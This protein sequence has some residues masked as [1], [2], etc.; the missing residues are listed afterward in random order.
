M[1]EFSSN[2]KSKMAC[3]CCGFKFFRHRVDGALKIDVDFLTLA[4][5]REHNIAVNQV[6]AKLCNI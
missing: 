2:T 4:G 5:G 6:I 1:T 3:D